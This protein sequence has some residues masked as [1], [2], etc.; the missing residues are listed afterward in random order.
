MGVL[1]VTFLRF[2]LPLTIFR[3]PLLGGI[4]CLLL[5]ALDVVILD[6]IDTGGFSNYHS[7]DKYLDMYY[8]SIEAYVSL[9][10]KNS[11]AR[12]TSIFLFIYRGIGVVLFEITQLRLVL[13][14]FQNLFENF[15]LFYLGYKKVFKRDP[16]KNI[17]SLIIVLV[18]CLIPKIPQEYMLHYKQAQPWG[19]IK[20]NILLPLK[21]PI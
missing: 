3:W 21:I 19:W 17:R 12:N 11:L 7:T 13:F 1:V 8:L 15:Y 18:I 16:I 2:F 5:D 4:V 9:F 10:W 6:I 20:N 14:I